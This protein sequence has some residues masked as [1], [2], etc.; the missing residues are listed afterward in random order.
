M[1]S[2]FKK[3]EAELELLIDIDKLKWLKKE[4]EREYVTLLIDMQIYYKY[5]KN[6]YKNKELSYLQY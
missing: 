2:S 6:Y 5:I 1:I 3:T 4:L